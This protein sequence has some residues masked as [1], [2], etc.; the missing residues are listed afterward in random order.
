MSVAGGAGAHV[1]AGRV[2]P[3]L[4]LAFAGVLVIFGVYLFLTLA[5][6]GHTLG[7]DYLA[8]DGAARAWLS[9]Q[10]PYDIS[11]TS[12]G[13]C[14]TFQYPPPFLLLIA[15]F[16]LLPPATATWVFIL[17]LALCVPL[18]VLAMPVPAPARLITLGLA[19]TSWPVLFAIK[20]GALGPLLL[21]LFALAWRW[22]DRP[23][24]LAVVTVLGALAKI[25]P[26]LLGVWMLLT[27]RYRA[28]ALTVA[29]AVI[30]AL[31]WLVLKPG[32]WI[33]F[34]VVERIVSGTAIS[35]P[36]NFAPASLAYFWGLPTPAAEAVG[37]AHTLAVAALVVAM[38]RRGSAEASLIVTAVASQVIAPVLWDH[39]TVVL[40]LPMAWLIAR[41]QWW[42]LVPALALNATFVAWIPPWFWVASL[43]AAM[44]GV[45]LVDWRARARGPLG[46]PVRSAVA[47]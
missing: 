11:V 14:G 32:Y 12:A 26:G 13:G 28:A 19:G 3:A 39:Y 45:A 40:F 23:A 15:P 44:V 34:L 37:V 6:A 47:A 21:L 38:A 41:R 29:L 33:D 24:R 9:G 16:T 25:L 7:C 36:A 4:V 10:P 20:V 18:A 22:L 30:V 43:D 27:G 8:Y 17:L 5:V 46:A 35:V 2:N 1:P 31:P 42:I